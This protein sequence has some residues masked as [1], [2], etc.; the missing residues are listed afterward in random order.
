MATLY[1]RDIPDG[2]YQEA[3]RIAASQDRSLSAF[4]ATVLE[5]AI[6]EERLRRARSKALS[7]IRRRRRP[8]PA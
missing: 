2:I 5:Q 1:V 8:L 3:R 6:D 4:V 7:A